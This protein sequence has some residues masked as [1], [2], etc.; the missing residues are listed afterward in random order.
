MRIL[1]WII[2]GCLPAVT[3]TKGVVS[4]AP[5]LTDW[6]VA[7][8]AENRLVAVSSGCVNL[9]KRPVVARPGF[10]NAEAIKSLEPELILAWDVQ[11]AKLQHLLPNEKI[12]YFSVDS[13]ASISTLIAELGDVLNVD[14]SAKVLNKRFSNELKAIKKT[15][16]KPDKSVYAAYLVSTRPVY[17]MTANSLIGEAMSFCGMKNTF[18]MNAP[19]IRANMEAVLTKSLNL[20]II[21]GVQPMPSAISSVDFRIY[22]D[23]NRYLERPNMQFLEGL[24]WLCTLGT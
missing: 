10:I 3:L 5:F 18:K 20:L 4:L 9:G 19:A 22:R 15:A 12:H 21:S 23:K 8:G 11:K 1:F 7:L 24:R 2:V 17:V 13:I 14:D 6:V 16:L